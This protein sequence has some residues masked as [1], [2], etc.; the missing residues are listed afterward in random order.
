MKITVCPS[1]VMVSV[2]G[3][4]FGGVVAL[5]IDVLPEILRYGAPVVLCII[6]LPRSCVE[7][8]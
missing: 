1:V 7:P 5:K 6:S 4:K 3:L 8:Y 2:N